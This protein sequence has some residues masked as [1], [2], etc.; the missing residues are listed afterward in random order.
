MKEETKKKIKKVL[1]VAGVLVGGA[2]IGAGAV[3]VG[4]KVMGDD[5]SDVITVTNAELEQYAK[6]AYNDGML[7]TLEEIAKKC[8]ERDDKS[9]VIA[10]Y[11]TEESPDAPGAWLVGKLLYEEPKDIDNPMYPANE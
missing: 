3:I 1:S 4:K 9:L 2:A 11:T 8:E 10:S 7:D 6:N 5:D